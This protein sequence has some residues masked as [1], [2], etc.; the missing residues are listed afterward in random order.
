MRLLIAL[1][2]IAQLIGLVACGSSSSTVTPTLSPA[3]TAIPLETGERFCAVGELTGEET[4]TRTSGALH[5][6][7]F[8]IMNTRSECAIAG[9]PG[10]QW[11]DAAGNRLTTFPVSRG[12][13]CSAGVRDYTACIFDEPIYLPPFGASL[14]IGT[15]YAVQLVVQ[16]DDDAFK[17]ECIEPNESGHYIALDFPETGAELKIELTSDVSITGCAPEVTLYSYGPLVT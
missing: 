4:A 12:P 13:T 11:Y 9:A 17:T 6:L 15:T 16:L 3:V 8:S 5:F 1:L 2:T 10:I 7:T 14:P